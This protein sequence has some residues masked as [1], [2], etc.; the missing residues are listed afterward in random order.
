MSTFDAC[1]MHFHQTVAIILTLSRMHV[2]ER[3]HRGVI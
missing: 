3:Y 2:P 1:S